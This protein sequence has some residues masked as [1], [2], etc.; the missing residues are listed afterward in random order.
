MNENINTVKNVYDYIS[1][2]CEAN[3]I[4]LKPNMILEFSSRTNNQIALDYW[5]KFYQNIDKLKYNSPDKIID[6]NS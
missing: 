3:P 4:I 5:N 6:E 2:N 1:N